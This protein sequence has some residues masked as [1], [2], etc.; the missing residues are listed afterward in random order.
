MCK[1]L[2][3]SFSNLRGVELTVY[4]CIVYMVK[5]KLERTKIPRKIT[6]LEFSGYSHIYT[7]CLKYLQSLTKFHTVVRRYTY[8][9]FIT[10]FNI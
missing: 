6:D 8:E 9:M 2:S 5:Y 4:Y 1:D 3:N 7:M 10:I